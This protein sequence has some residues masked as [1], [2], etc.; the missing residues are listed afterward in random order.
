MSLNNLALLL[1]DQDDLAGARPLYGR[2]RK[3]V[4]HLKQRIVPSGMRTAVWPVCLRH[5]AWFWPPQ[6]QPPYGPRWPFGPQPP[7]ANA[8]VTADDR[9]AERMTTPSS[10]A[11]SFFMKN[12]PF[13]RDNRAEPQQAMFSPLNSGCSAI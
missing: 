10:V 5:Q 9:A 2:R 7:N 1:Q 11:E 13:T 6:R 12:L 8:G 3:Q 4:P